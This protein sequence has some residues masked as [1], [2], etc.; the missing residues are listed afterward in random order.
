M[1]RRKFFKSVGYIT[2]AAYVKPDLIAVDDHA[3]I[4]ADLGGM[5]QKTGPDD[6]P[7]KPMGTAL[8]IKP[9]RV[10]WAWDP[11]A[12][13]DSGNDYNFKPE[14]FDQ[15][16][17]CKMFDESV[18]ELTGKKN[19]KKSWDA[20]FTYFNNRKN[21]GK[22]GYK[23][24][25][26]IFIKINQTSSRG[27]LTA[28]GRKEGNY[29]IPSDLTEA[30]KLRIGTGVCE[31]TPVLVTAL[32]RQ[33]VNEYG[34]KHQ[35]III[36]DPQNPIYGHNYDVWVEEFPGIIYADNMF[37]SQGRTLI[38]P[39][40]ND[41]VFYSDKTQNDKLYDIHEKAAYLINV[42]NFKP[43]LRAGITLTAKNHFGSQARSSA[44][45]LH[46]SHVSPYADGRPT[47]QGYNKYRVL[48]D[49]MGS[50]YLGRNTI[51]YVVDGLRG[52]GAG[53]VGPPVKYMMP[54]FNN[55]WCN[56][57]FISQDQVA[58]ES[59]CYDF[60]RTEWDGI[61]IHDS[62][63]NRFETMPSVN[64]VDDYLH[65]AADRAN[66]PEGIIYDPDNNGSP[67]SS[68]GIHEHWNNAR[69]K[70]YSRNLGTGQGIELISVGKNTF[71]A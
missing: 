9:G 21:L 16:I 18:L 31:T 17:V 20:L 6:G 1:K 14:Y 44:G 70:K 24:G 34:V 35:D 29:Y 67:L 3:R 8:G 39:S 59:V 11:D 33:L 52:G 48:V 15:D 62:S 61:N 45:H 13:C 66:W 69:D 28:Q 10:V 46:Y 58:I 41:L 60:L 27:R 12:T 54:P 7:N 50:K 5:L 51:L 38:R 71:N 40:A 57:L 19:I 4:T 53:E 42:A 37:E 22:R 2:A 63:N 30:Q 64:G 68:L 47:N 49:L 65:Q 55:D 23:P 26:K 56:S 32:L 43:H 36:A 25:E